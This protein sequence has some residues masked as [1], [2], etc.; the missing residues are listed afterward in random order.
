MSYIVEHM[1]KNVWRGK[2]S[3]LPEDE[4]IHGFSCRLGGISK[5]PYATL[6]MGLHV[7]DSSEDVLAN[8]KLFLS[9][10]HIKSDRIVAAEQVHGNRVARVGRSELGAGALYYATA[11][12]ETDALITD[13]PGI[14]LF[15]CFADCVPLFF[16]DKEK[17][18]IG[19][20]HAGWKGTI[21]S[22]AKETVQAMTT[23]FH[24]KPSDLLVGIGPSIGPCCFSVGEDVAD[25]FRSYYGE[26]VHGI[27]QEKEGKTHINL[28]EANRLQLKQAGVLPGNIFSSDTCTSC[29]HAWYYSYR[30][31]GGKTGRMGAVIALQE[32]GKQVKK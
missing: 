19:L 13:V 12:K 23:E 8:R 18:A 4:V 21:A 32:Y 3:D 28:W 5:A 15:M 20:A 7:G 10:L 6:D 2:F 17:H 26:D 16:Y 27:L 31:D 29:Q 1:S 11:C 30:A 14:P 25:A 22:V 24:T 9:F